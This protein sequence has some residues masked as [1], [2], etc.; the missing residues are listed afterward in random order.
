MEFKKLNQLQRL[1]FKWRD[2]E[3]Y[4]DYKFHKKSANVTI[5]QTFANNRNAIHFKHSGNSGDVIYS[6]PAVYQL[7]KNAKAHLHLKINESG[8]SQTSKNFYHPLGAVMLNEKMIELLKPLLLF[9]PQIAECDVLT[10]QHV[11]YDLDLIRSYPFEVDRGSIS[12]WYFN[13]FGVYADLSVPWLTAPKDERFK[14]HIV[15]ARSHRYRSPGI[16]YSFLKK[17][18]KKIFIGVAEEHADMKKMIPDIEWHPV[19]D[20]LEMAAIINGCRLFIGNQSFPF[21]LAEALKVNRILEVYYKAPNVVVE[22]KGGYDFYY[23]PHFENIVD[24]LYNA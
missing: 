24:T 9:Q 7:A 19:K 3:A 20:F 2:V 12:R 5:P 11:D 16:D 18:P 1:L 21:S 14:E 22:G 6:L 15:I 8:N 17:Y 13:V 23:Q 10:D 4:R